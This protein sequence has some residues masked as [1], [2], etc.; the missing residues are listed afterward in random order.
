MSGPH[1]TTCTP[2]DVREHLQAGEFRRTAPHCV[3]PYASPDAAGQLPSPSH[4]S[5]PS[6]QQCHSVDSECSIRLLHASCTFS[7]GGQEYLMIRR[8][9]IGNGNTQ[10]EEEKGGSGRTSRRPFL[11]LCSYYDHS[12]PLLLFPSWT[13]H[14]VERRLTTLRSLKPLLLA[15]CP[16]RRQ[17]L[18]TSSTIRWVLHITKQAE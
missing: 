10:G 3:T 8:V 7:L 4:Y 9:K 5:P 2:A 11:V 18:P 17:S 12:T 15:S 14:V 13:C 6:G 1:P 16:S